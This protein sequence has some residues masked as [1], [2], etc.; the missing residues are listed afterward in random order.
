VP[1]TNET[2]RIGGVSRNSCGGC[3][4]DLNSRAV[5]N[6]QLLPDMLSRHLG[7]SWLSGWAAGREQ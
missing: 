7:A 6:G 1:Q 5:P 3:F 4:R 2:P